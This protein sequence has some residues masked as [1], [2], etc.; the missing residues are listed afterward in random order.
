MAQYI[1]LLGLAGLTAIGTLRVLQ[2]GHMLLKKAP[3]VVPVAGGLSGLAVAGHEVQLV[4]LALAAIALGLFL[5]W[6]LLRFIVARKT[7]A[8]LV[9]VTLTFVCATT[10]ATQ[11]HSKVTKN[12]S[13]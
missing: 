7:L 1:V 5:T 6:R 9:I 3:W 12:D 13:R 11:P 4:V 2:W 10:T 8:M